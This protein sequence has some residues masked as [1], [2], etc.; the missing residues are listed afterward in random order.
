MTVGAEVALFVEEMT[1]GAEMVLFVEEMTVGA[2]M[3]LFV[4]EMTVLRCFEIKDRK[5]IMA[6]SKIHTRT[7]TMPF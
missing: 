6:T 2:E 7:R 4:E 3:A 5:R 1:V